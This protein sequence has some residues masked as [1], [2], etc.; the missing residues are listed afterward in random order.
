MDSRLLKDRIRRL[1][2]TAPETNGPPKSKT[3]SPFFA[4]GE[5]VAPLVVSVFLGIMLDEWLQ[6][7]P[8]MLIILFFMGSFVGIRSIFRLYK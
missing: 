3:P 6:T 2:K 1:R 4:C 5:L 8:L 7:S